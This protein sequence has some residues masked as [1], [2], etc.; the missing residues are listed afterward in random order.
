MIGEIVL[1]RIHED[2]PIDR[3]LL[4]VADHSGILSGEL[5][6]DWDPDRAALWVQK[7][8]FFAP[9]P[10]SRTMEVREIHAG[11]ALGQWHPRP[12]QAT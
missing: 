11:T 4:V 3:P 1:F 2:P 5:F 12:G 8:S 6:L 10:G 7:N 9:H